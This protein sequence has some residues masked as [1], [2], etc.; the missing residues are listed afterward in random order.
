MD[1]TNVVSPHLK[2]HYKV[3]GVVP[4]KVISASGKEVDLRTIDLATADELA[5]EGFPYLEKISGTEEK[6][7]KV[8][9][10]EEAPAQTTTAEEIPAA[11]KKVGENKAPK[12]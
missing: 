2:G 10:T 1:T 3:V 11:E 9:E 12:K 7:D 4:G 5:K 8:P 6:S